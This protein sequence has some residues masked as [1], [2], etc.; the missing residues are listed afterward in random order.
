MTTHLSMRVKK[1]AITS[2]NQC[3]SFISAHTPFR[4]SLDQ[5]QQGGPL[6]MSVTAKMLFGEYTSCS[7]RKKSILALIIPS[8]PGFVR[9]T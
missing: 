6:Q 3:A 4:A 5:S 7:A 2:V 1:S 9:A 8:Q